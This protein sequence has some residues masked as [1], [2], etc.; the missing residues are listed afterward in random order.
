MSNA[1]TKI[2][3]GLATIVISFATGALVCAAPAA[4]YEKLE[5]SM[6]AQYTPGFEMDNYLASAKTLADMLK[7]ETGGRVTVKHSGEGQ[8]YS[9]AA[10]MVKAAMMGT[11]D[12]CLA[13]QSR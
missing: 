6:A 1:K 5:L 10:E 11:L 8:V 13:T 2:L 7:E 4:Q 12:I 3:V 9:S